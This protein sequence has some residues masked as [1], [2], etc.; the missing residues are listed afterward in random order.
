MDVKIGQD[1]SSKVIRKVDGILPVSSW[2]MY[3]CLLKLRMWAYSGS[4]VPAFRILI[5]E[6]SLTFFFL[7]ISSNTELGMTGAT[8]DR[9]TLWSGVNIVLKFSIL[10]LTVIVCADLLSAAQFLFCQDMRKFDCLRFLRCILLI[11][12]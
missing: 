4:D 8:F 3:A 12:G 1:V 10:L 5:L 2:S 11:W 9:I 6:H 7:K